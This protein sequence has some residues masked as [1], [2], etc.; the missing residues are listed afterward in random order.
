MISEE[1]QVMQKTRELC[2]TILDEPSMRELR[3]R[4]DAFMSDDKTRQE[5]E[6]LVSKGQELQ[7]K[8]QN[9]VALTGDEIA[10]FEQN[11]DALL[12]NPVARGYLDAQE[13]L[14]QVQK[15]I[16]K[17]VSKTLELGRMPT[18]DELESSSCGS[19]GCGCHGH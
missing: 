10:D 8:Q 7:E 5:Y 14:H 6:N 16:Q 11:R 15:S 12:A 18:E 1:N 4:I 17:Y 3:Q 19:G 2:Q 9:A 13:G